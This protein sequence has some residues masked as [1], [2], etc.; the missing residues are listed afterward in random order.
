MLFK[1]LY[2]FNEDMQSSYCKKSV[3][4]PKWRIRF[5]ISNISL[6]SQRDNSRFY[7]SANGL[8]I[9]YYQTC[10]DYRNAILWEMVTICNWSRSIQPLKNCML[11]NEMTSCYSFSIWTVYTSALYCSSRVLSIDSGRNSEPNNKIAVS[12]TVALVS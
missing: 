9:Y 7:I 3:M 2:L 10:F 6:N 11:I 1:G 12:K 4:S 5:D 8:T